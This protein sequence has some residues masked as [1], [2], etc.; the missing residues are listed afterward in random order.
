[1]APLSVI[2]SFHGATTCTRNAHGNVISTGRAEQHGPHF[3]A[4]VHFRN[5]PTDGNNRR[6]EPANELSCPVTRWTR[7]I[8]LWL[9]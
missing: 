4:L 7:C 1:M 9:G 5:N 2:D 6:S 8:V 3:N